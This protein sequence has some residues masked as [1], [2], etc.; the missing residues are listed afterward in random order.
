MDPMKKIIFTLFSSLFILSGIFFQSCGE[1][2]VKQAGFVLKG[3]I[4]NSKGKW[5]N[6]FERNG[7][8]LEILD[9]AQM[10]DEN[11]FIIKG[12]TAEPTRCVLSVRSSEPSLPNLSIAFILENRVIEFAADLNNTDKFTVKGSHETD[13]FYAM[14]S[15]ENI[16]DIKN[17]I[18]T[19]NSFV[20]IFATSYLNFNQDTVY[21]KKIAEKFREKFPDSKYTKK[22]LER[23]SKLKIVRLNEQAPEIAYLTP[24]GDSL[25]L[26]S[27]KGKVVLLDFWA[28]WC[29]RCRKINPHIVELY[30]K[31]K[32]K[33]F[34]V[35]SVSLD[36]DKEKWMFAIKKD[37]LEWENHV[38]ELK[39]WQS[40]AAKEYNILHL[41]NTFLVNKDGKVIGIDLSEVELEKKIKETVD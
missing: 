18:D 3:K 19:S 4:S 10:D 40:S 39:S 6:L 13:M 30:K 28:S 14:D 36:S 29:I 11:E 35:F 33:N 27:L 15:L 26:S 1:K 9:S 8:Q 38:S 12:K 32:N 25:K 22:F 41:P 20:S 37:K 34:T 24:G 16:R 5:V 23:I 7:G 17:F 21:V 2:Q 31:Y